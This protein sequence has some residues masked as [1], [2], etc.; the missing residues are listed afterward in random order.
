MEGDLQEDIA[1]VMLENDDLREEVQ[2][3]EAQIAE[4]NNKLEELQAHETENQSPAATK[5]ETKTETE[6]GVKF[7]ALSGTKRAQN[8]RL[9]SDLASH[10][11]KFRIT[12]M[13]PLR[14]SLESG[15]L[16]VYPCPPKEREKRRQHTKKKAKR[17]PFSA[18]PATMKSMQER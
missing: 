7:S 4:L 2:K 8:R 16:Y 11:K 12:D 18:R 3:K 14:E 6:P 15:H 5:D 10:A 13:R 9:N 17:R 1:L